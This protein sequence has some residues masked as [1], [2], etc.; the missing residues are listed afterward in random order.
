MMKICLSFLLMTFSLVVNAEVYKWTDENGDLIYSDTPHPGAEEIKDLDHQTYKAPNYPRSTTKLKPKKEPIPDYK[1]R[2]IEPEN[3]TTFRDNGGQVSVGISLIPGL[4]GRLKHKLVLK[5]D[6]QAVSSP[7]SRL[8]Y[9]LTN[10]ER[11]SH[12]LVAEI[13]DKDGK[14]VTQSTAV[15]FQMHRTSLQH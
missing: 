11:G 12:T 13:I 9:A 8:S 15:S 14:A 5:L 1:V 10:V 4:S 2:V 6:G 7:S 3:G